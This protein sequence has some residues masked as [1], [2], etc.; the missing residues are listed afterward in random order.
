[1]VRKLRIETQTGRTDTTLIKL[2]VT[3]NLEL[4]ILGILTVLG[5]MSII[6]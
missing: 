6:K 4:I 2:E 3:E 1:L 5:S